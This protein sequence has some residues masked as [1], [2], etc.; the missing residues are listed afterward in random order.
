MNNPNPE[1]LRV[2]NLGLRVGGKWLVRKL[3]FTLHEGE[4]LVVR[5]SSGS[6]KTTLLRTLS[7]QI[8]PEEG[9][10]ET[11]ILDP[12]QLVM[13]FQ[14][15]QLADGSSAITNALCGSL[16]RKNFLST[17]LGFSAQEKTEVSKLMNLLGIG[18]KLNQWTSTLSRG[19]RQRLA[20]VR[21]L[22]AKPRILFADEPTASLDD[23][24]ANVSLELIKKEV[25]CFKG[26]VVCSLH[27]TTQASKFANRELIIDSNAADNCIVCEIDSKNQ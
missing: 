12:K 3:S 16:G 4:F 5:G 24:W 17:F 27:G 13:I 18:E 9:A 1:L 14:D 19:E 20:I 25:N 6:G 21:G 23:E 22:F 10:V 2:K 11:Q 7:G 8:L 26:S 15:L